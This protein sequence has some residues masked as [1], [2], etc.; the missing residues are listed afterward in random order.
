MF[1][2][3]LRDRELS[4]AVQLQSVT[5]KLE[6]ELGG[7]TA[8]QEELLL[9]KNELIEVKS[10]AKKFQHKAKVEASKFERYVMFGEIFIPLH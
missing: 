10:K 1:E 5:K 8:L 3:D 2:L 6:F 4:L 9:L 7:K